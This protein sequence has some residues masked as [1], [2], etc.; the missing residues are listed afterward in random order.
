MSRPSVQPV[1][2][3]SSRLPQPRIEA[4]QLSRVAAQAGLPVFRGPSISFGDR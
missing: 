2:E 3:Q 1:Q 4:V